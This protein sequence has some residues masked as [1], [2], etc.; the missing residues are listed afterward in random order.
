MFD[1]RGIRYG[2][3]EESNVVPTVSLFATHGP[4]NRFNAVLFIE[5]EGFLPLFENVQLAERYDLA[6]MS[7]KGMSVTAS[8]LLVDRMC[9]EHRI[10]L[11]VLH[12]FDKSGFSI[13]GSLRRSND[14]YRFT[15]KIKVIDLGLRL[16]DVQQNELESESVTVNG[17]R[18][19]RENLARN[20]ATQEEIAFL[21]GGQRVELNAMTA[22]QLVAWI[23][24]KLAEHSIKKVIPGS[25]VLAQA[26]RG[27]IKAEF[28]RTHSEELQ[29]RRNGS[30]QL[31]R[32]PRTWR[33]RSCSAFKTSLGQ[34]LGPGRR[35]NRALQVE[36]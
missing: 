32:C 30:R 31:R 14:R 35:G 8:R 5:K 16:E 23:E 33:R 1:V 20:G 3:D 7:T 4:R 22:A 25:K 10:P 19:F 34:F 27:A 24:E 9:G 29:G 15:N 11:L 13:L 2:D 6:I 17:N 18:K 21:A 26:Y 36:N 28:V 12:D